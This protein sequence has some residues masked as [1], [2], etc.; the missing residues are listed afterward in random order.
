MRAL[1]YDDDDD[2]SQE[3]AEA[4][5]RRGYETRM[6]EGRADFAALVAEFKPDLIMLDVHMPEFNGFEALLALANNPRKREI[7]VIMMSGA[8]DNL[9]D[10]GASLSVAHE[11]RLLGTLN[12]PFTS[13]DMDELLSGPALAQP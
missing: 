2:L 6:R 11:I 10:A 12:K 3:C 8:R 1:I 13:R 7:S 4:L 9:L 5:G